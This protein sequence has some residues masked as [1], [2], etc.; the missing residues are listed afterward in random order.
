MLQKFLC[1]VKTAIFY[2]FLKS[3]L[4]SARPSEPETGAS[5]VIP[6]HRFDLSQLSISITISRVDAFYLVRKKNFI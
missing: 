4:F 3:G 6:G 1:L 5:D 2:D